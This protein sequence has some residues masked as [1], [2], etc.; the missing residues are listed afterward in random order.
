MGANV[1]LPITVD[2]NPESSKQWFDF[3]D[4]RKTYREKT[5][6]PS[7]RPLKSWKGD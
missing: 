6:F 7:N 2:E 5:G 4:E 3:T 1:K